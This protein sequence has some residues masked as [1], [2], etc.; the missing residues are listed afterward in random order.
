MMTS[1][2]L[3]APSL[4]ASL[5]YASNY[6]RHGFYFQEPYWVDSSV[7]SSCAIEVTSAR[8]LPLWL[9]HMHTHMLPPAQSYSSALALSLSH[10]QTLLPAQSYSRTPTWSTTI[11]AYTLKLV[12][13]PLEPGS[14]SATLSDSTVKVGLTRKI[15]DCQCKPAA[16]REISLP[17]R[18]R[19]EDVTLAVD[20]QNDPFS[21]ECTRDNRDPVRY[22]RVLSV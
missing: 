8:T 10:T 1:L 22:T 11:E 18:P 13:P 14:I 21:E 9:T 6:P 15:D 3:L 7:G 5:T 17:Y 2:L 19:P 12:L 16:H 4:S 20:D